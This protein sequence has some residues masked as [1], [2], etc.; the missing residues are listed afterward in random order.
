MTRQRLRTRRFAVVE[1]LLRLVGVV[2]GAGLIWYGAMTILLAVK[3]SP[4]TINAISAYRTVY[5]HLAALTAAGITGQVRVIVAISGVAGFVVL[6]PLAWRALPRPYLT[7]RELDISADT[8]LGRTVIA[9]RAIERTVELAALGHPFVVGAAGRY[10]AD[11][12]SLAVTVRQA[13][14]LAETLSAVQE[15]V[16]GALARHELPGLPINV[17]LTGFTPHKQRKLD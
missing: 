1:A 9:P 17:T 2:A 12:V 13:S 3:I 4:H 16:A 6:A 8:D 7:R 5:D 10:G 14:E 11:D 15:R